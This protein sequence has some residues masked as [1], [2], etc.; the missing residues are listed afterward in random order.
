MWGQIIV[1][2]LIKNPE[3]DLHRSEVILQALMNVLK[4]VQFV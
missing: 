1:G 2:S 4:I 3:A